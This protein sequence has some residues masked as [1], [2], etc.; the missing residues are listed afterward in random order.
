[1]PQ[2]LQSNKSKKTPFSNISLKWVLIVPFVVQILGAVGLVG[3]LSYKSD[4]ESIKELIVE[5]HRETTNNVVG[6]L[7]NY[8][9]TPVL[10]NRINADAFRL[11]YLNLNNTSQL[12]QYLY[13]QLQ[14]FPKVS[15]IMVGTEKGVFRVANRNPSPS[16]LETNPNKPNQLDV[17]KVDEKGKKTQ[18]INSF[19]PF[20][21]QSRPWYKFAVKAGKPVRIPIFQLSDN[22]DLSL[23]S[24]YPIYD[25]KTGKLLGVFSAASDL[26]FFRKYISSLQ[27]GKNGRVFIVDKN[28]FLIGNSTNHLP[29][30]K[31][32]KNGEI[33]LEKIKAIDSEDSLIQATSRYLTNQFNGFNNINQKLPL[34]FL[35]EDNGDRQFVQ[36]VPYEGNLDL[37]WLIVVVVPES[38]FTTKIEDNNRR[39][40]FLSFLTLITTTG[41]GILTARWMSAPISSLSQASKSLAKG[42]D[43]EALSE[44]H[45]IREIGILSVSFNQMA[46]QIQESFNNVERALKESEAKYEITLTTLQESEARWQLAVEGSGDGTWDWNPQTN[47]VHFSRQWKLMLGYD[48]DEIGDR[49]E[50]WSDRVHPDDI[51]SCYEDIAKYL[52]GETTI[53]Q[54]E[55]RMLCKDG[56]YKWILDRGQVIERDDKG[57]PLRFIGTHSDI[58][59]RI[60]TELELKDSE[61]KYRELINNLHAGMVVHDKN[62]AITLC[63]ST[64][65]KLLGLT[66]EQMSG[67]TAIDPAWH[68]F[69]ENSEIM[70]FEAYPVNQVLKTQQPLRNYLVGINRPIDQS[71]VWV[72]VDAFPEFDSKGEIKQ[73]IVTF[74]DISDRKRIEIELQQSQAK[75]QRL[76]EDIGEKF[77]VFSHNGIEGI[78]NY[79]SGGFASVFGVS[80]ENMIDKYWGKSINWLP[81]SIEI[82][83]DSIIQMTENKADFMQFEMSFIHPDNSVHT[84][85]VS[86]HPARDN[87]GNVVA[88]EGIVEDITERKK[89]EKTLQSQFNK[90]I[91]LRKISDKIR[92]SLEIEIILESG[93]NEIGKVF[94]V[95]RAVIFTC[96]PDKEKNITKVVSV[97]VYI[98]GDYPSF[99][100]I[101]IP[102]IGNPYM[103]TLVTQEGAI[104]VDDV[105]TYLPLANVQNI[106]ELMQIKSLL[107]AGT[108]YQGEVNGAIGLH[109]CD[110]HHHWTED[111]IELLE[112]LAGQFGIAIAQSKLLK[113][114]QERLQELA[115]KNTQLQKAQQSA[116]AATQAKSEFL[117]NMSHEIRTPMNGVLGMTQLLSMTNLTD[118]QQDIVKTI[119]DSGDALLTIINDILDFSKIE[120]GKLELEEHPF[121]LPKLIKSV[122]NL[123]S[124]IAESKNL[125]LKYSINPDVATNFLGDT[126]RLR[127]ILLNLMGNAI[128]F[129]HQGEIFMNITNYKNSSENLIVSVKDTGIGIDGDRLKKLFQPFS[130]ADASISRKYGGTGLGLA[131]SKSLINLMGGT[132][133][134][135][136]K[137]NIGGNPDDNWVLDSCTEGTTFYFTL[138]LK[139]SL[140]SDIQEAKITEKPLE[141]LQSDKSNLKIL[142]AEDNKVNQKVALLTLKKLGY[143]ADIANNGVEVLQMLEKQFYDLILMDM[144]MPEMDGL[145]ATKIIRESSQ[146]QPYIIA[147][148]ANALEGDRQIC[149]NAGMNDYISKPIVI[150]ELSQSLSKL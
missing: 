133:W 49:I 125:N 91:L 145:T 109:H 121:N 86:Q 84:I 148:T 45:F 92:Q 113:Q 67:K 83:T 53:Y 97:A 147:L 139:T 23:N 130:Q 75:F 35:R 137:G 17:Y 127:Q 100:N 38:D 39:T 16:I 122:S 93:V 52:R 44:N 132:I 76:V 64:A 58:H 61:R 115:Q 30:H 98:S 11:G 6:Y 123:M 29:F 96:Y 120:S 32:E 106:M 62:S 94:N 72:L 90:I 60:Q 126:S 101:E 41:V 108:F 9:A 22:S 10:I 66:F 28:G 57:Q 12:E 15:H 128:K 129:T 26:N 77:V 34:D 27:I 104:P 42:E 114:E 112:S 79:L 19:Q 24:S 36:V 65:S 8:L 88:I 103:E 50:E 74:I 13:N 68:F 4:R 87:N 63:N 105:T 25:S 116:E 48:D 136:S 134:I 3:Y 111:E 55:H 37:D 56:T 118:E 146:S 43:Y 31:T 2:L 143:T 142:L 95:N 135:E 14:Q 70:P 131:I 47:Q 102:V 141:S 138:R 7:D 59:N 78:V 51:A 54:N 82:A 150:K 81:E 124:Q 33:I 5:I 119:K 1:M 144:Q 110:K 18:L 117:A 21:L 140:D 46:Q 71:R 149:L 69:L 20:N 73:V 99:L 80:Q 85:Q 107:A 40:I 89:A